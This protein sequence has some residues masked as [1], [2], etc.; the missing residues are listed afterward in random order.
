[1][2]LGFMGWVF[3]GLVLGFMGLGFSW[4]YGE[5]SAITWEDYREGAACPRTRQLVPR[6]HS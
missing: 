1:M 6:E 4:P 5:Y 2:G 3:M